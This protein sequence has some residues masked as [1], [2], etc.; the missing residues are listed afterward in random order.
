MPRVKRKPHSPLAFL[1]ILA[2]GV[3]GV[4]FW[5]STKTVL[6]PI[7]QSYLPSEPPSPTP[8][9]KIGTLSQISPDGKKTIE[10]TVKEISPGNLNYLINVNDNMDNTS[11]LIHSSHL[12]SEVEVMIPFNT[13]SPDNKR[14]FIVEKQ[15]L[16]T[17]FLLFQADGSVNSVQI[18]AEYEQAEI[19]YILSD[20]TGWAS[21][22]LLIVRTD[23]R[24]TGEPGPSYWYETSS[25]KFIR[26]SSNF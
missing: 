19:P 17:N 16:A 7:R 25:R 3:V 15:P 9:P 20:I 18:T 23:E 14:F 21:P 13:W 11:S 5:F 6:S 26:L 22:T 2:I 4:V 8:N 1:L 10:L 24:E 12:E